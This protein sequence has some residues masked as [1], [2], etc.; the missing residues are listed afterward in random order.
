VKYGGVP[1]DTYGMTTASVH[2]YVTELLR[3][4]GEDESAITKFQT[5][6]PDGDLGSN[7]ILVSKDK[8]IGI[9]DGSGVVYDPAGLN[10][11]ELRRLALARKPVREFT[12]AMLGEGA[13]LVTCEEV[14][15]TLP[16]GSKWSTGGELRDKFHLTAYATAD[17]FV[18]CGGRPNSITA[19]NVKSLF[20]GTRPKFRI[21]V[22]GA[23]L[24]LSDAARA[25]LED[26]G[27]HV[28]KDAS[29][30]KGGVC[31]SSL[32]VLASLAL[33]DEEHTQLMTY[34]PDITQEPPAF[35]RDYVKQ[36]V[37]LIGENARQEFEAIWSCSQKSGVRKIACT[38]TLSVKI[39]EMNDSLKD[40][41]RDH[42]APV[43]KE[44]L[45]RNVISRAVPPL[46][47]EKLGVDGIL[48]NVPA[49]YVHALV[50]AWVA[51]R[52]VYKCGI[53]ASYEVSFFFF[54][55]EVLD[56]GEKLLSGEV[57]AKRAASGTE[58]HAGT[59]EPATSKPRLQ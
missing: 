35:Y 22:E 49:N 32:E 31:S 25:T 44:R 9:A 34:N 8:T 26:A 51:S 41:L 2:T 5:G 57:C 13:F 53:D 24:F 27:V 30:N 7:E 50:G 1:H 21:I 40:H 4:L 14:N 37:A 33:P 52:F 20:S 23:N 42:M 12:R 3:K 58:E 10:R 46:L 38:K 15:V 47:L 6:G 59:E 19:E 28:F 39:N 48:R 43:E 45:I 17:L 16:D 56:G 11:E 36:A 29:T 18:P 54:L 55:R